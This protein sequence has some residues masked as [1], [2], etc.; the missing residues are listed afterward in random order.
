MEKNT[1][2]LDFQPESYVCY[3]SACIKCTTNSHIA[4][5]TDSIWMVEQLEKFKW[6]AEAFVQ[7]WPTGKELK[8]SE[9]YCLCVYKE[10]NAHGIC[11]ASMGRLYK[12]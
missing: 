4:L 3:I 7:R 2:F 10:F 11:N 6:L 1:R 12:T 5:I 8:M 9:T